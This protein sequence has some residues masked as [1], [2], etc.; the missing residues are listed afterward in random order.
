MLRDQRR[1]ADY[2]ERANVRLIEKPYHTEQ[3]R[4]ELTALLR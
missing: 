1:R 3:L 4:A 2:P